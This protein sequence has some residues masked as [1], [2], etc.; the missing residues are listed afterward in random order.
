MESDYI[1]KD[2]RIFGPVSLNQTIKSS[3]IQMSEGWLTLANFPSQVWYNQFP[4]LYSLIGIEMYF[5]VC[6]YEPGKWK[7]AYYHKLEDQYPPG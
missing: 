2:G 6:E 7:L 4:N 1:R 5:L 3:I